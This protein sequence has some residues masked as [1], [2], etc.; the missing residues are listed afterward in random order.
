MP[1]ILSVMSL[2]LS[3][4]TAIVANSSDVNETE[5]YERIALRNKHRGLGVLDRR[6]KTRM[7]EQVSRIDASDSY[8]SKEE[9]SR[10]LLLERR[11]SFDEEV[12]PLKKKKTL[13]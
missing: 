2:I 1:L 6:Q 13:R 11:D 10:E 9:E 5:V 4:I 8:K 7:R 12:G 3:I